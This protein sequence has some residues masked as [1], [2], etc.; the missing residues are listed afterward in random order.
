MTLWLTV[1]LNALQSSIVL[2]VL[3]FSPPNSLI[4]PAL[5]PLLIVL[6]L[7]I[8][9]LNRHYLPTK[10]QSSLF[11]HHT[12]GIFLQYLD[13]ALISRW[14][15]STRGPTSGRGGLP[16]TNR[17]LAARE[18]GPGKEPTVWSRLKW[19]LFAITAWRYT[20]T[21]WEVKNV[22]PFDPR[23]PKRLPSRSRFLGDS[24]MMM[25][26]CL[27]FLDLMSLGDEP[28]KNPIMFAAEK[29]GF[30]TRLSEISV[31]EAVMR[32]VVTLAF[33]FSVY[34]VLQ[35]FYTFMAVIAVDAGVTTIDEWPPLF[36]SVKDC[37]SIRQ[38]WGSVIPRQ[39]F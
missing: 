5:F 21:P 26:L 35:A 39:Y 15:F 36:G 13:C 32:V 33:W 20:A 4:R 37:Y 17:S 38:F 34:C 27:I 10:L 31:E 8:L 7:Y 11:T 19:G 23:E 30:F 3:A 2:L 25:T 14:S 1:A 18:S 28:E 16:N 22:P 12:V 6:T 24:A 29:V 9:P